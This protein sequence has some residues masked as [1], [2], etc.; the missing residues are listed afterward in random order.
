MNLFQD[1]P[2]FVCGEEISNPRL[3]QRIVTV[4]KLRSLA[5]AVLSFGDP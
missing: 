3:L 4:L 5:I 1:V 2:S